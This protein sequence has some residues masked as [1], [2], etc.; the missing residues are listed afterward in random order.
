MLNEFYAKVEDHDRG[1]VE[2]LENILNTM[3]KSLI[4]L[5]ERSGNVS[6]VSSLTQQIQNCETVQ[7]KLRVKLTALENA[8][9][10]LRT[11]FFK[12]ETESPTL[13]D[14]ERVLRQVLSKI[15]PREIEVTLWQPDNVSKGGN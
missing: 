5:K 1:T 3:R 11:L 14:S 13:K 7:T 4:E 9:E 6:L 12:L 15:F 2:M 10:A 8:R